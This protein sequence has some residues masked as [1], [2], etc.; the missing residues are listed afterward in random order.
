MLAHG[1]VRRRRHTLGGA[2][3]LRTRGYR[4]ARGQPDTRGTAGTMSSS[5]SHH[6]VAEED[7]AAAFRQ[8]AAATRAVSFSAAAARRATMSVAHQ[9]FRSTVLAAASE[10][11]LMSAE[12]GVW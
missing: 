10:P 3:G 8:V 7:D 1:I 5:V 2:A 9:V 4:A 11:G 12:V 6:A